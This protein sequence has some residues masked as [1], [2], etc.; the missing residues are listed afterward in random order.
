MALNKGSSLP[1]LLSL[2]VMKI[3]TSFICY[4]RLSLPSVRFVR[5]YEPVCQVCKTNLSTLV[6]VFFFWSI[7][8]VL[9]GIMWL[10]Y[11]TLEVCFS[12][13]SDSVC[14]WLVCSQPSSRCATPGLSA[15]TLASLGGS[16]SR[17]G[18]ADTGSIY[19]PDTSLSELRVRCTQSRHSVNMTD[20]SGWGEKSARIWPKR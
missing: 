18:S 4:H 12:R 1:F 9:C 8:Q 15:A 17:R 11:N 2:S 3:F 16:S 14:V 20:S 10:L 19:D 13:F 6:T 5:T 7:M